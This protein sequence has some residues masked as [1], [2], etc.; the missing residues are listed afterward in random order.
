MRLRYQVLCLDP[1]PMLYHAEVVRRDGIVVGDVRVGSYGHTLGGAVGLCMV[2]AP[3]GEHPVVN[4]D[5]LETG[6]WEVEIAG[7]LYPVKC[8]LNPLYDPKNLKIKA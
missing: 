6:K 4:K 3:G 5:F 1:N 2:N 7:Q 8:S